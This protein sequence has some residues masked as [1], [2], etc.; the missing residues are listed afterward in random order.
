MCAHTHAHKY[1]KTHTQIRKLHRRT[2]NLKHTQTHIHT[3]IG[4]ACKSACACLDC[5]DLWR[6]LWLSAAWNSAAE[7]SHP[8]V[9]LFPGI[10]NGGGDHWQVKPLTHNHSNPVSLLALSPVSVRISN[11]VFPEHR[12][13]ELLNGG[14][15][16][17]FSWLPDTLRCDFLATS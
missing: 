11:H 14:L 15:F 8:A 6:P 17:I 1:K 5:V 7:S 2:H 16:W 12:H 13:K 9:L 4:A 10:T 3:H